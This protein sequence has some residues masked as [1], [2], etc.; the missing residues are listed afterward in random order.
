MGTSGC[1]QS[2]IL[3]EVSNTNDV[4]GSRTTSR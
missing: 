1:A 2:V 3:S 4:E